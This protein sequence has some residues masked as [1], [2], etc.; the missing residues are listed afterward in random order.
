MRTS[1]RVV[2]RD[3]PARGRGL[4]LRVGRAAR[5]PALG[6]PP[7]D[8]RRRCGACGELRGEGIRRVHGDE[9]ADGVAALPGCGRCGAAHV[10]VHR[11]ESRAVRGVRGYVATCR[12]ALDRRGI[13]GRA[14]DGADRGHSGRD[15]NSAAARGTGA[16]RHPGHGRDRSHEVPREGRER[17]REAGRAAACCSRPRVGVSASL[18]G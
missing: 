15:R 11:G 3:G 10:G 6:W 12:G 13:S 18:A 1:V 17:G 14:W 8:R 5:R 7:C 16:S 2:Q 9:R 4:V